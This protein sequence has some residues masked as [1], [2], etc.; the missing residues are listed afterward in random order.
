MLGDNGGTAI[1][2]TDVRVAYASETLYTNV[3]V[4]TAAGTV[5]QSNTLG[6]AYGIRT[7]TVDPSLIP[8]TT[9]GSALANYLLDIYENPQLRFD[10]VTMALES[11]QPA[12]Q[13]KVLSSDIW[14]AASL[15]YTP[16]AV[17]SAIS[18]YQRIVG[19]N[20]TITPESH[21]TTF[22]LAEFGNKF[23]LD[24]I[25]FGKLDINVLGY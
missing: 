1:P 17:G 12:D 2:Y 24:S 5:S 13:V 22:N 20:H 7:L 11:L 4:V 21:R 8:N 15:T 19:V 6:T 23:R 9:N 25:N 18:A 3:N 16:S 10:S 14:G